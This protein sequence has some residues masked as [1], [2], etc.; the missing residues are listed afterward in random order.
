MHIDDFSHGSIAAVEPDIDIIKFRE[1]VAD[2]LEKKY[3][4]V[5]FVATLL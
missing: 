5:L 1:T 4:S 2:A 3:Y